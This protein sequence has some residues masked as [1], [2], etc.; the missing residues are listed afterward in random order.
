MYCYDDD[1]DDDVCMEDYNVEADVA[2]DENENDRK[3]CNTFA[4]FL[5]TLEIIMKARL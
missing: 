2:I 1:D 3:F 4:F 5:S